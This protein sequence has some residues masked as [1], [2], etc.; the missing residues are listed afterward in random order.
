MSKNAIAADAS[1]DNFDKCVK[2][3]WKNICYSIWIGKNIHS[4]Y[5]WNAAWLNAMGG[6]QKCGSDYEG[7]AISNPPAQ[8]NHQLNECCMSYWLQC[9]AVRWYSADGQIDKYLTC[10]AVCMLKF[11]IDIGAD[12][13]TM[14]PTRIKL[15]FRLFVILEIILF[16]QL[17]HVCL[18]NLWR[19]VSRVSTGQ[20]PASDGRYI[21]PHQMLQ[22]YCIICVKW[23]GTISANICI[24]VRSD[25]ISIVYWPE[26][27]CKQLNN[28][29]SGTGAR[30]CVQYSLI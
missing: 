13:H 15:N 19:R 20:N 2:L 18:C 16:I 30:T 22:K 6:W 26:K 14:R 24:R 29:I 5:D 9:T 27:S 17:S 12:W 23:N 10:T 3:N 8:R 4:R 25:N 1:A 11:V 21:S 28:L 7:F